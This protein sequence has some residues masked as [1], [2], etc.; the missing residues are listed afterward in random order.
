MKRQIRLLNY[1]IR[2]KEHWANA[3]LSRISTLYNVKLYKFPVASYLKI[4]SFL[5]TEKIKNK[6]WASQ[7]IKLF[8]P[9]ITYYYYLF[10]QAKLLSKHEKLTQV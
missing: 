10:Q 8:L 5:L 3:K 2:T 7:L 6:P 1:T 4:A 9:W